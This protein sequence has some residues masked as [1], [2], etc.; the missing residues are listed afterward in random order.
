MGYNKSQA[1]EEEKNHQRKGIRDYPAGLMMVLFRCIFVT[2][3]SAPLSLSVEK[4]PNAWRLGLN[5]ELIT[6]GCSA[7]FAESGR[8]AI[9]IW[10]MGNGQKGSCYVA[11]FKPLEVVIAV[12]MGVTFLGDTLYLGSVVGAA[13]IAIGFYAVIWG[14][15]QE[16]KVEQ[17]SII[18]SYSESS[19]PEVPLLQ[20]KRTA[21]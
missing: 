20:N 15:A 16:K 11:M 2:I 3:L 7:V 6:I 14:K 10:A 4:D 1:R 9:H 21:T 12:V 5:M 19:S 18:I 17:E 13:V 8:P